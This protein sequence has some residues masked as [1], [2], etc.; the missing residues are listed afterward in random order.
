MRIAVKGIIILVAT[1]N[2]GRQ[3]GREEEKEEGGRGGG[4]GGVRIVKVL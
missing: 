3:R 4:E 1:P 2:G